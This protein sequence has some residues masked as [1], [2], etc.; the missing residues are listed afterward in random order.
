MSNA[1]AEDRFLEE[2]AVDEVAVD[3]RGA[4]VALDGTYGGKIPG[5]SDLKS[6]L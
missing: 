2:D 1:L 3:E 6:Q 5:A 4:G